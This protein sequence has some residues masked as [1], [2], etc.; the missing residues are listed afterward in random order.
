MA[1]VDKKGFPQPMVRFHGELPDRKGPD[2]RSLESRLRDLEVELSKCRDDLTLASNVAKK[3]HRM[4][5]RLEVLQQKDAELLERL[6]KRGEAV[7]RQPEPPWLIEMAALLG[8]WLR[9]WETGRAVTTGDLQLAAS[10]QNVLERFYG[11]DPFE[12]LEELEE[13]VE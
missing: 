6:R 1:G 2:I 8:R 7:E 10:T 13:R 3:E 5:V 9:R 12:E 11:I 4:R